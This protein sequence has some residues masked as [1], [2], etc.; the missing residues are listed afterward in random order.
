MC[1]ILGGREVIPIAYMLT[2][3]DQRSYSWI[4]YSTCN[5]ALFNILHWLSLN[6]FWSTMFYSNQLDFLTGFHLSLQDSAEDHG[7]Y[8]QCL[9]SK[10]P[11]QLCL[12]NQWQKDTMGFKIIEWVLPNHQVGYD[13]LLYI[14]QLNSISWR[15]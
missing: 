4:L 10:T 6:S 12:E 14:I 3:K 13:N 9:T 7:N 8:F 15:W 2:F 1:L 11:G 5:F